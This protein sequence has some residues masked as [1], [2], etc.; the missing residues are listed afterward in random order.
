M[1]YCCWVVCGL[2]QVA[3]VRIKLRMAVYGSPFIPTLN[4]L[5]PISLAM[6]AKVPS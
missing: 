4:M 1:S 6:I 5:K 3:T 2:I